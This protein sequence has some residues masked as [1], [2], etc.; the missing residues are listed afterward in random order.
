MGSKHT[1]RPPLLPP[2]AATILL[3][4]ADGLAAWRKHMRA[5]GKPRTPP[6]TEW[7][8]MFRQLVDSEQGLATLHDLAE[9]G[10]VA[11]DCPPSF[12]QCLDAAFRDIT[13]RA[14]SIAA[15]QDFA[16]TAQKKV[17]LPTSPPPTQR[18]PPIH[19]PR[20][21]RP[22]AKTLAPSPSRPGGQPIP[23]GK[24]PGP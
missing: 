2:P 7:V 15:L 19:R 12:A 6:R 11:W 24:P 18:E 21:E 10:I 5:T 9:T 17:V 16:D 14:L 8:P 4:A 1:R 23:R 13:F 22:H 20:P 3:Y